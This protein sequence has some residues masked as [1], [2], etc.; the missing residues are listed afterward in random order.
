MYRF[1]C[2]EEIMDIQGD[3]KDNLARVGLAVLDEVQDAVRSVINSNTSNSLVNIFNT[4]QHRFYHNFSKECCSKRG[5]N[6]PLIR[7]KTPLWKSQM[8]KVYNKSDKHTDENLMFCC[9]TAIPVIE[10][11]IFDLTLSNAFLNIF[12]ELIYW[13]SCLK[14]QCMTLQ[15]LLNDNKHE[16]FHIYDKDTTCCHCPI[17]NNPSLGDLKMYKDQ[18]EKLFYKKGSVSCKNTG[19]PD[20]CIC[21]FSANNLSEELLSYGLTYVIL[22]SCCPLKQSI[23]ALVEVR[24]NVIGHVCDSKMSKEKYKENWEIIEEKV[25]A[26]LTHGIFDE[27]K[28]NEAIQE[29]TQRLKDLKGKPLT[30]ELTRQVMKNLQEEIEVY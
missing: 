13:P 4:H 24:N 21:L 17:V 22:Q 27:K 9:S 1:I 28:R 25:P 14:N 2:T 6:C 5:Y 12:P 19:S 18:F 16:L 3:E 15:N 23:A 20:Y 8:E 10:T 29:F 7:K 26:L 30:E 11:K